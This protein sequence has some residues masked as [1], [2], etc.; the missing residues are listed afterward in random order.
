[1]V[2]IADHGVS[3]VCQKSVYDFACNERGEE[4]QSLIALELFRDIQNISEKILS[5]DGYLSVNLTEKLYCEYIKV[6]DVLTKSLLEIL[7][8]NQPCV[9]C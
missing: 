7:Q 1:V 9:S 8:N 3:E 5:G 2:Y 6:K 4:G